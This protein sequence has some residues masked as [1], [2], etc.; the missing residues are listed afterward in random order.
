[1][2]NF[3]TSELV[4]GQPLKFIARVHD[5]R[6]YSDDNRVMFTAK[7]IVESDLNRKLP[8][9]YSHDQDN[10]IGVC[11]L[12]LSDD[13]LM[14]KAEMVDDADT[15]RISKLIG[16]GTYGVSCGIIF[17]KKNGKPISPE[18]YSSLTPNDDYEVHFKEISVVAIPAD[19]RANILKQE[20]INEGIWDKPEG[21]GSGVA[22]ASSPAPK[23]VDVESKGRG[24]LDTVHKDAGGIG[25]EE[26][27][28]TLESALTRFLSRFEDMPIA[29]EKDFEETD[30][31]GNEVKD[32]DVA[33][34]DQADIDAAANADTPAPE[35]TDAPAEDAPV[36]DTEMPTPEDD[37]ALDSAD[38]D[39]DKQDVDLD[40]T[41][42]PLLQKVI[43][44]ITSL[45]KVHE[46][47]AVE[48]NM[49][50]ATDTK[51]KPALQEQMADMKCEMQELKSDFNDVKRK[52][53]YMKGY[54]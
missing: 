13:G 20:F 23:T 42:I 10:P 29:P 24:S 49:I 54:N 37:A 44:M 34:D 3:T 11:T 15:R 47:M 26:R 21:L 8:L 16:L 38:M 7:H 52:L 35:T 19:E 41:L 43:A 25:V 33:A 5:L 31:D 1:M 28:A 50:P 17:K 46:D 40:K 12:Y 53:S 30:L 4:R 27:L 18:E 51:T 14:C 2:R 36:D 22:P 32:A 45:N 6:G 9:L 39:V 48:G